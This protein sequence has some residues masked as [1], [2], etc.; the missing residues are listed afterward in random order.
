MAT[1]TILIKPASSSCNMVCTYCFYD[2][3]SNCRSVKSHGTIKEETWKKLVDDAFELE[4]ID[5]INFAFQGGEPLMAGY[6][7]FEQ[8][9]QYTLDHKGKYNVEYSLQTNGTMLNDRY[10]ELFKKYN[11]LIG[12]SIDGFKENHD[13]HRTFRGV[14]AFDDVY[15]GFKLLKKYQIPFNV[16]TVLTKNLSKYPQELYDFY[17]KEEI[18][19][20]QIIPC[21]PSFSNTVEEDLFACTP[22][23]FES[24]YKGL[25]QAWKKELNQ[26]I[27]RSI[28]L[29]ND[30][31]TVF[32]GHYPQQCGF[33]GNC[34]AQCVVESNG[35]IYPCDFYVLDEWESGNVKEQ[36]LGQIIGNQVMQDFVN[37]QPERNE[38]P[39]QTCPFRK[40]CNGG[41]KRLREN[42]LS[43]EMCGLK[44]IYEIVYNDYSDIMMRLQSASMPENA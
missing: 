11:F 41:C 37:F 38:K 34:N 14:G 1:T 17:V 33:L 8:F 26:G 2:D 12:I 16:L 39:C 10:C 19:H 28:L 20:I 22:K 9:I 18:Y 36:A 40:I 43:D 6:G 3:V 13:K 23:H 31:V 42:F 4:N 25:Y 7:F 29:F 44:T 27:Y 24:F 32:T 21:M 35:S 15:R 5:T 30:L